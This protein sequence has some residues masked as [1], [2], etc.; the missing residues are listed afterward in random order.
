M[1]SLYLFMEDRCSLFLG[2]FNFNL[3]SWF[4]FRLLFVRL[5]SFLIIVLAFLRTSKAL[6]KCVLFLDFIDALVPKLLLALDMVLTFSMVTHRS[7]LSQPIHLSS[8]S[9]SELLE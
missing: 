3:G 5:L 4:L 9:F 1:E 2:E 6:V 7:Q 8:S